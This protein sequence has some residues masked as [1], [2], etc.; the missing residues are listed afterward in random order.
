MAKASGQWR[1]SST[2]LS[3]YVVVA[4][5]KI[6]TVASVLVSI[7]K[8]DI[9]FSINLKNAYFQIPIHPQQRPYLPCALKGTIYQSKALCFFFFFFFLRYPRFL[10]GVICSGS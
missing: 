5:F 1:P 9:M 8:G 4:R 3:N 2:C 7:G 10:P 6:E